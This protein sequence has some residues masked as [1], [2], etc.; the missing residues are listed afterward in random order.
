MSVAHSQKTSS[1]LRSVKASHQCLCFGTALEMWL[2]K[3][4][5]NSS[6]LPGVIFLLSGNF[7]VKSSP[8]LS[9]SH[10]FFP[11]PALAFVSWPIALHGGALSRPACRTAYIGNNHSSSQKKGIMLPPT[12]CQPLHPTTSSLPTRDPSKIGSQTK[13]K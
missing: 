7:P 4:Q 11:S 5:K 3:R 12:N 6:S 8:F 13:S 9:V 1:P 2:E 10:S